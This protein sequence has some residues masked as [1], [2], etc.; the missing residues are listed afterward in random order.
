MEQ[1]E[2][3]VQGGVDRMEKKVY[4]EP[5]VG[6]YRMPPAPKPPAAAPIAPS[7]EASLG[8][9]SC[10]LKKELVLVVDIVLEKRVW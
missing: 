2:N 10:T 5:D 6:I 4:Y 7:L 1:R 9:F 3:S 8:Y